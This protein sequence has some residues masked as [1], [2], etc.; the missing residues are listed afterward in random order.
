MILWSYLHE[1]L[2]VSVLE[3]SV[4][5]VQK[6][7]GYEEEWKVLSCVAGPVTLQQA[8]SDRDTRKIETGTVTPVIKRPKEHISIGDPWFHWDNN[9]LVCIYTL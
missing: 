8:R 5:E 6:K 4:P 1:L 9:T 2:E 7:R 3:E